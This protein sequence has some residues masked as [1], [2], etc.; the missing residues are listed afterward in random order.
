[1][2]TA[3]CCCVLFHV[4]NANELG[5]YAPFF[6]KLAHVA[7][8]LYVTVAKRDRFPAHCRRKRIVSACIPKEVHNESHYDQ[9]VIKTIQSFHV[10]ASEAIPGRTV[11]IQTSNRGLDA[12]GWLTSL[13][14]IRRNNCSY[15]YMLKVHT[16]S[17]R[18]RPYWR[19]QLMEA[20]LGSPERVN[21]CLLD[22]EQQKQNGEHSLIG[23]T[24]WVKAEPCSNA[25]RLYTDC[26]I[27]VHKLSCRRM[28]SNIDPVIF[29]AGTIFWCL[30]EPLVKP[31]QAVDI[32]ALIETLPHGY[33]RGGD[34][35]AHWIERLFGWLVHTHD[36]K[37]DGGAGHNEEI[38]SIG[39][40]PLESVRMT[41]L[42]VTPR[43][44]TVLR[45][46]AIGRQ[47][48]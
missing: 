16:K 35:Q 33:P 21:K 30:Y 42:R 4:G 7:Y 13:D 6:A 37:Q 5:Y 43:Q 48:L 2:Q 41:R 31:F 44:T 24:F 45:K 12:G 36:G 8:D 10:K 47:R 25:L 15:E 39:R 9:H 20:V 34:S 28:V 14:Y 17:A 11:I 26:L 19:Q 40:V 29:I 27:N 18:H 46:S 38:L 22:L 32:P 23:S 1:M 3:P